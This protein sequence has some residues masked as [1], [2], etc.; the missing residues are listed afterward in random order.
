MKEGTKKLV[1]ERVINHMRENIVR[2]I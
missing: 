2:W 1:S